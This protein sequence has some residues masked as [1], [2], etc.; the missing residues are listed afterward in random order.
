MSRNN[1]KP[2]ADDERAFVVAFNVTRPPANITQFWSLQTS[3]TIAALIDFRSA[4]HRWQ[5]AGRIDSAE[6]V[7]EAQRLEETGLSPWFDELVGLAISDKQAGRVSPIE[8][9]SRGE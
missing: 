5:A 2:T 3:A 1:K 6:F 7:T 8:N 9:I 4:L